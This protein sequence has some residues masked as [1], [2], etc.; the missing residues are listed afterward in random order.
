MPAKHDL[1]NFT[2]VLAL[3]ALALSLTGCH[4]QSAMQQPPPPVVTVAPVTQQEIT[5]WNEFTGHTDAVESVEVRPRV[6]GHIDQVCFQS[7]QLVKKGD[8]LFQIDP[9]WYQAEYD[10]HAAEVE[11]AKVRLANAQRDAGRAGKLLKTDAIS[12]ESADSTESQFQEAKAALQAAQ[13]VAESARLDLDYTQVRSPI[14]GRVSRALL[15]T[16]NYVSGTAGAASLL[17]TVVSVDPVYVYADM[18]ENAFLQFNKFASSGNG[19]GS[20]NLKVPVEMALADEDGFPHRG[21]VESFDNRVDAN[22]GTILLRAVFANPD[23]RLVPGMYA[24]IRVPAS[25]RHPAML[26]DEAAIGTDQAQKYVLTVGKGNNVEYRKVQ[27]GPEIDGKRIVRSGVQPG[28]KII[29]NGIQRARPGQPVN[30]QEAV[31]D[32]S[33]AKDATANR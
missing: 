27:L 1:L 31:A 24:R 29:V 15:T 30:P 19:I 9:R 32:A 8:V 7:G 4:E 25:D 12:S 22:T 2:P 20:G 5:E 26:V 28:D 18:D 10:R 17:T 11:Q 3:A 23:G 16:G 6:S 33:A 13:A 21:V 14:N